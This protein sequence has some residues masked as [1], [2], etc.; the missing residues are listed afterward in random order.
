MDRLVGWLIVAHQLVSY[1]T[2]GGGMEDER[3]THTK[4]TFLGDRKPEYT[5]FPFLHVIH[6]YGYTIFPSVLSSVK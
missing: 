2:G 5:F 3:N 6:T 4:M 1:E